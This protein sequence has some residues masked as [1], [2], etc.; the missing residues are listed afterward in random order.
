MNKATI[1]VEVTYS[2]PLDEDDRI[3]ILDRAC[4]ILD[5]ATGLWITHRGEE[6]EVFDIEVEVEL[7][8][9]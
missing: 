2:A 9:E 1:K 3:A 5:G 4:R 6:K 8:D 7:G